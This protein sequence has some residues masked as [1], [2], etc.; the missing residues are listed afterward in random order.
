MVKTTSLI[1]KI[2]G[3]NPDIILTKDDKTQSISFS[4]KVYE[5]SINELNFQKKMYCPGEIV[6]DMQLNLISSNEWKAVD[7]DTLDAY[8]VGKEVILLYGD[9]EKDAKGHWVTSNEKTVCED[10]FIYELEP[11]YHVDCMFI[12][13][14][15]YSPDK[16][17]TLSK[18][19][20]SWIAQRLARDIIE[21]QK[22]KFKLPYKSTQSVTYRYDTMK[23]LKTDKDCQEEIF[24]YLVQYNESFYDFLVRTCNRWGEFLYYENK[25][26]NIGY[27]DRAASSD[28]NTFDTITYC[29]LNKVLTTPNTINDNYADGTTHDKH[30][31]NN[32]LKKGE[33]DKL[34][35]VMFCSIDDG[36][37]IWGTKIVGNL[38]S[39]GKNLFD[40][41]VD[42]LVDEGIARAQEEKKTN[43]KN[44]KFDEKYFADIKSVS[45]ANERDRLKAQYDRDQKTFNQFSSI[46]PKINSDLYKQVVLGELKT[47]T[48]AVC[49]N[50][51][52]SFQDVKLGDIITIQGGK[53]EY[54]V[55]EV[56][57]KQK[58][59]LV[60]EN[61]EVKTK[62]TATYYLVA[63]AMYNDMFY[64][65][66]HP[67]GHIRT[68]GPQ[69]A[70]V[71]DASKDDPKRQGRVRVKFPWQSDKTP[72]LEYARPGGNKGSGTYNR[73]YVDEEVIV[74]FANDNL[75]RPYVIGALSTGKQTAPASTY[76]NDIVH[77]TPGGHAIKMTDGSGSG[78]TKFLTG[79]TPGLKLVSGFYPGET[80]PG[81]D[82]E[83]SNCF[84]GNIEMTDK[85]GIFS[86]KGS[87]DDRNITIKSPFGDVKLNAF[88]GITISAPNG[89]VKIQG[90]NV[91][92][93][94]G[95]N[96]TLT[97]GKNI[98]DKW[99]TTD[100]GKSNAVN[101]GMAVATAVTK[102]L[103]S[104]V[105]GFL[106]ISVLR[107][108]L[109]VFIRPVEGKLQVK[110]NRY[111]ALEA[112]K[113]KTVYPTDA[114]TKKVVSV[115]SLLLKEKN[116]TKKIDTLKAYKTIAE[117]FKQ[118][119][120]ISSSFCQEYFANYNAC[121]HAIEGLKE[122]IK[123]STAID[124]NNPVLPCKTWDEIV[125]GLWD[126]THAQDDAIKN[127][128]GFTGMLK[129]M[130][131]GDI[132]TKVIQ[133][134]KIGSKKR[135]KGSLQKT[136][137]AVKVEQENRRKKILEQAKLI[138]NYLLIL[139][140]LDIQSRIDNNAII[141][142]DAK[143]ALVNLE[144]NTIFKPREDDFNKLF[145]TV[146]TDDNVKKLTI[147]LRRKFFVTLV[148]EVY[149]MPRKKVGGVNGV[150]GEVPT[151]PNLN[152]EYSEDDWKKY[153]ESIDVV[154]KA[155]DSSL[156]DS[157]V[158][159]ASDA[160]L[161][162]VAGLIDD[163]QDWA[164]FGPNKN[165]KI[166]FSDG[167]TTQELGPAIKKAN[168]S[169]LNDP[170]QTAA[171]S[172]AA[173]KIV[174]DTMNA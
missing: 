127:F 83:K 3:C 147:T 36:G 153:V 142:N 56:G 73:H 12:R 87:T 117:T 50:F 70:K 79:M 106:D 85:Y 143:N 136:K 5:L 47:A 112:G 124:N 45:N 89:D 157:L 51:D 141:D 152:G 165:G 122:E 18:D 11:R 149:K 100:F 30:M 111:L 174:R 38:L 109:E 26:L 39:S 132:D 172:S 28:I 103:A 68:S 121:H 93:E 168:V 144:I 115:K 125:S 77:T 166:L 53:T 24:P 72:W 16:L 145:Q 138:Q 52:T 78:F 71:T 137:N 59:K 9:I 48:H 29:D 94:A 167:C 126:N 113:G 131:D 33:Y 2:R 35:G 32:P 155:K 65:T 162:S 169:I 10:Y 154:Y 13:M 140:D 66:V 75:E 46:E 98:K 114:Y 133:F 150:G 92:I 34:K 8:F 82:F 170:D 160:I 22:D 158:Q 49:I 21:G 19:S 63:T 173:A 118:V 128:L 6:A 23:V 4:D 91:T 17:L 62:H 43:E 95:N 42:T 159:T 14:K 119:S 107:H 151:A 84:E 67:L 58:E 102:K 27:N 76:T 54:I 37:D 80:L 86:I 44:D 88:T 139:S 163:M 96:L 90:K 164:A 130:Q 40:F 146:L 156:L 105:G 161:G 116:D 7:K 99:Y 20:Q 1:L 41:V 110:S 104:M 135:K 120:S 60:V 134:F 57:T 129:E 64:P 123:V 97:S 74:A 61:N 25:N 171:L 69:L 15:M 148:D 81:F 55:V 101:F 108:T 31:L